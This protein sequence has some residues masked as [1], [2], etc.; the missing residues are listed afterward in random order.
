MRASEPHGAD[1][2]VL[3]PLGPLGLRLSVIVTTY[4]NVHGL[5]LVL[6]GLSRQSLREF[7]IVVADDGSGPETASAIEDFGARAPVP[8][9]HLWHP[10]RGVRK[11]VILNRAIAAAQG[12]YLIFFDGDCIPTAECL[13]RHVRSTQ[14]GCYLAGGAVFLSRAF[15]DSL[16]AEDVTAGHLDRPGLWWRHVNKRRRLLVSHLPV[17]PPLMDRRVPRPPSWRGGNSSAFAQDLYRVGGF[18]ERFTYGF[19]DADLGQRLQA[20]GVQAK[21]I[22][23]TCPVLHVEHDRPYAD[24]SDIARSHALYL[25]NR[26]QRLVWTP[27]GLPRTEWP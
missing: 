16:T 13:A 25:E 8:V 19:E 21:S 14:Q 7:E 6:A 17:I 10:H 2:H 15:S 24:S 22:R 18:D 5:K 1:A 27:N 11:S 3:P 4:N 9:H 26:A 12:N 23:Y 20:A